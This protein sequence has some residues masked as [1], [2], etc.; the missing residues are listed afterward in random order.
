MET[1]DMVTSNTT[2]TDRKRHNQQPITH[3]PSKSRHEKGNLSVNSKETDLSTKI[4]KISDVRPINLYTVK[5]TNN[6]YRV[7]IVMNDEHTS[8]YKSTNILYICNALRKMNIVPK[9]SCDLGFRK[10][11]VDF[12]SMD[13]ANSF[14]ANPTLKEKGLQAYIPYRN[15]SRKGVIKSIDPDFDLEILKEDHTSPY[16]IIKAERLCRTER[17][18]EQVNRIPTTS[19]IITFE[20]DFLPDSIKLFGIAPWKVFPYIP[21]VKI[22][23]NCFGF[24]HTKEFCKRSSKCINCGDDIHDNDKKIENNVSKCARTTRCINCKGSHIPVYKK[25]PTYNYNATLMSH[26]ARYN[27]SFYEAKNEMTNRPTDSHGITYR[28]DQNFPSIILEDEATPYVASLGTSIG[29]KPPISSL[30]RR[31][32]RTRSPD[33]SDIQHKP[34]KGQF[35]NRTPTHSG[36][37]KSPNN[38][39]AF[40]DIIKCFNNILQSRKVNSLDTDEGETIYSEVV[41]ALSQSELIFSPELSN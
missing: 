31:P 18:G 38:V 13:E 4:P 20:G 40:Q 25:C 36:K 8:K 34:S 27:I 1:T 19:I 15:I 11:G 37:H 39:K 7:E 28:M 17:N 6:L 23:F 14:I 33:N 32:K 21:K 5:T 30:F 3:I 9:K 22:C 41:N 35:Y 26:S 12:D 29:T 24:G 16:K 2:N 10:I